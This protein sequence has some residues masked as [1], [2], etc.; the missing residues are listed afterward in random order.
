VRII[1]LAFIGALLISLCA[2]VSSHVMIGQ[3]RPPISP[4]AVQI[5]FHPPATA[6]GKTD[7]VI[8]RLKE[9]AAKLG[10][11]G[12]LLEGI[13]DQSAGSVSTAGRKRRIP[14]DRRPHR[15]AEER[16]RMRRVPAQACRGGQGL[17]L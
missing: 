14:R 1:L 16:P 12:V 8:A 17:A 6:Q 4:N 10:G 7:T 15:K 5:Y 2:C 13:G 11:N 3:A 9:E